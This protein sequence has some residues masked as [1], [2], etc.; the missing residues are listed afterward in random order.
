ML[1]S[2]SRMA[3]VLLLGAAMTAPAAGCK[4]VRKGAD[5]GQR[6]LEVPGPRPAKFAGL[7]GAVAGAAVAV[8][9]TVVLLPT[10]P[11]QQTPCMRY[12]SSPEHD[13]SMPIVN[14]PLEYGMGLGALVT[15]S[16][17]FLFN[18]NAGKPGDGEW[19]PSRE[20]RS[21]ERPPGTVVEPS[22]TP[23]S[24]PPPPPQSS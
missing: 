12:Q 13:I 2:R 17:F 1:H 21:F 7:V 9:I 4:S 5:R 19:P 22:A 20:W 10:L 16:P 23:P 11:F 24:P 15:A 3:L 8:P 18:P 14:A 6:I